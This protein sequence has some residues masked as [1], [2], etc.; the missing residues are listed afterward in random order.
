MSSSGDVKLVTGTSGRD[1]DPS[2]YDNEL[3]AAAGEVIPAR[4]I[5]AKV[6]RTIAQATMRAIVSTPV[7]RAIVTYSDAGRCFERRTTA[8]EKEFSP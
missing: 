2:T 3:A 6:I 5:T 1:R 8:A 7:V 4:S